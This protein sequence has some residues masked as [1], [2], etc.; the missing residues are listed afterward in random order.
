MPIYRRVLRY[1]RPFVGQTT[2]GLVL[3][4][5]AIALNLLKPWP[6]KVIVDDVLTQPGGAASRSLIPLFCLVLVGIQLGWGLLNMA[7]NYIFVRIGLKALLRLRTELYAYLQSLSLK[8]HDAR[9]SSDSSFRVAYD[10]QAI[11][12]M[13]NKGFTNI[14][15]SGVTLIGTFAV[16]VAIDW[17]LTL[18]S[19]GVVPLIVYAIYFFANR[20]RRQSTAIQERESAVLAQAQE[21]LSSVRMVHAFGREDWEVRQFASHAQESLVANLRFTLTNVYSTL[22]ISTLMVAG[23]A[24]MYYV[25][26]LHVLDGRLTLGSLIVFSAYLL[27]LYQPLESLTH[28]AWA[29]EGAAAGATRCFEVL[30]RTDDV[31]DSPSALEINATA[32][33]IAFEGVDFGYSP[34]QQVLRGVD[35]EIAPSQIV[36]VVGGTGA[37]KST[38]LSL[39]PRFYDPSAGRVTI[40]DRDLRDLTK[41]SLRAQIGIV[42]QDTLLFS[43]TVRENIAYGRPDATEAEIIKA[44]QRAQADEFIRRMP[45]GYESTVGER[46]GHLSVGQR[47]RIGIARA[48]LKDAPI[49]LLDEPT[50]ALDPTTEAAI[51]NTIRELMSG[52]TTLIVTHRLATVHGV[53]RIVVLDRGELVEQG[54]GDELIAR[55]GRYA[56]LYA[57]GNFPTGVQR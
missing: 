10:S 43:T 49:L 39:V 54:T 1:Y 35:L 53:D 5:C 31:V 14:F 15:S 7:T 25:G 33:A 40:D 20:I 4:L 18:L 16:M 11:Q 12:T 38:L 26:S 50:S 24:A 41:K 23:T 55:G 48:F 44:A 13:F 46:G 51:M 8:Y 27:M 36:G 52:R 6:F 34:D 56:T 37:G 30:D 32:G 9:R 21:G 42:L 28:T 2:L 3:S 22:V 57:A 17:Q 29:M 45:Q 19:L 47:Q